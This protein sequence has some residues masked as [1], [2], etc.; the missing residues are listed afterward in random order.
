MRFATRCVLLAVLSLFVG[1]FSETG[2][3]DYGN[4]VALRDETP[5]ETVWEVIALKDPFFQLMGF[6]FT[7]SDGS[8]V[9]LMFVIT[10]MSFGI[11]VRIL[12]SKH[13]N[14]IVGM[15]VI[16]LVARFFLLHEFTQIRA[17]L[18][19]AFISAS[20]MYA[21]EKKLALVLAT[22]VLAVLAHLSTMALIPIV[23][24]AYKIDLKVKI[25][26]IAF[27]AFFLLVI[28]LVFD[29]ERFSRLAPYL[30]GEYYVTENTL[31]SSYFLFK[32]TI[33]M[34]L[35]LQWKSLTAAM[36]YALVA[37]AYGIFL[38]CIFLQ[39]DVLS[40][41]LGELTA[42]FDCLCFAYFFRY[43]LRLGYFYGYIGGVIVAAGFYFS[44]INIV[45]PLSLKF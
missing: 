45:N 21:M 17:S 19:I 28:G 13:Y 36:R 25:Y 42:V 10:F 34:V 9:W 22:M 7:S 15:A 20:V 27:M 40:L 31:L 5:P 18:G 23:L 1:L 8:L 4:Y 14:D 29:V 32:L 41:R 44:S 2:S 11:K 6:L 35:L 37:S 33:L 26:F 30:T 43:S 16:F 3:V 12:S 24:L 39:N 38:T